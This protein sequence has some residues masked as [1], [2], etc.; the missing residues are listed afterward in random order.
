MQL[1]YV[2]LRHFRRNKVNNVNPGSL[3][4]IK[5]QPSLKSVAQ[6]KFATA[7]TILFQRTLLTVYKNKLTRT[8]ND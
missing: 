3:S 6:I 1:F 2:F 5:T 7:L 8:L 4:D